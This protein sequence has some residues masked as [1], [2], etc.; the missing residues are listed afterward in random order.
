MLTLLSHKSF[1]PNANDEGFFG[2]NSIWLLNSIVEA[3]SFWNTTCSTAM[4]V[5]DSDI[6]PP[7]FG[8]PSRFSQKFVFL[9]FKFK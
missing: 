9:Q 1:K 2:G 7:E 3:H 6:V 8:V 4:H 5:S